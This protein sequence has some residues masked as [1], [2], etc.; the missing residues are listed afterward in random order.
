MS[1]TTKTKSKKSKATRAELTEASVPPPTSLSVE[2]VEPTV[3]PTEKPSK[4]PK[5]KAEKGVSLSTA[6]KRLVVA[7][8]TIGVDELYDRLMKD[9]P[10]R[11][12]VTIQTLRSDCITTLQVA[13]DAGKFPAF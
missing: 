11:S 12:K 7:T 3:T 6:L 5:V 8:P 2:T 10:G 4:P 9:Y 1:T 13:V